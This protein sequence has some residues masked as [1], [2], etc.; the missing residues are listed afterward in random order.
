[1]PEQILSGRLAPGT[2]LPTEKD[3]GL[4]FG[5]GRTT[6]REALQGLTAAGC[7]R[8]QAKKLIV[9]DPRQVSEREVDYGAVAVRASIQ[10]VRASV[11]RD[12]SSNG[13]FSETEVS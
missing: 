12:T 9:Q 7:V 3:I 6:V 8:R 13:G 11:V 10:E 2:P 5:V 4:A 1:M